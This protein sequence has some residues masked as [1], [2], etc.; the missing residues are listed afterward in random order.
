MFH[1]AISKKID[2]TINIVEKE[3]YLGSFKSNII[4]HRYHPTGIFTYESNDI[5]FKQSDWE[6][7]NIELPN[8]VTH[9]HKEVVLKSMSELFII[10]LYL[11]PSNEFVFSIKIKEPIVRDT[12]ILEFTVTIDNEKIGDLK[13]KISHFSESI[14]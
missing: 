7:F 5:W 2:F 14:G 3:D 11:K 10:H 4:I 8:L 6:K 12:C 9:K 1:F 13:N